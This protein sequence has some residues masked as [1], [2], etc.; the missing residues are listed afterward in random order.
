MTRGRRR[1][2]DH[3]D[4]ARQAASKVP[5]IITGYFWII[6]ILTTGMGEATSDYMVRTINP[7]I[8]V[9]FGFVGFV[10]ALVLQFRA[11]RYVAWIYWLACVMVSVFGTMAAD[12]LHIKFH[13][14]YIVSSIFF[15][16]MLIVV[17]VTWQ[18]SEKTLSI[19][20][21]YTPRREMFYWAA[22]LVTF[23]F[24]TATGDL[25]AI[26]FKLGFLASGVLFAVVFAIPAIGYWR[27][28]LNSVF[29]FWFAYIV[30]RP[31]GASFADWMAVEHSRG[32]LNLGRGPV[33]VGL[34]FLI[35]VF[36]AYLTVT[37]K[38]VGVEELP[39]DSRRPARHSRQ[40][41]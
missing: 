16:I 17:F 26:T 15:G 39:P 33:A 40:A 37:R 22:V 3:E 31:L 12:V 5:Q 13:V 18:K 29:A 4:L 20:S 32:G 1:W 10:V 27:F 28:G 41:A 9:G 21:I 8:A 19:H 14:P 7:V 30:T 11:R 6:K 34:T 25:T 2:D 38:D 24:G 36:V 23:A 35:V